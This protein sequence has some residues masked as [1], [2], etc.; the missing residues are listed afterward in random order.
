[1]KKISIIAL[2]L[3]G[4]VVGY[5]QNWY[6]AGESFEM[7]FEPELGIVATSDVTVPVPDSVTSSLTTLS[8]FLPFLLVATSVTLRPFS[9]TL[10]L[11]TFF[12][13]IS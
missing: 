12:S 1:M 9:S 2:A 11:E 8:N 4:C 13:T 5:A 7:F 10:A 6:E 3:L